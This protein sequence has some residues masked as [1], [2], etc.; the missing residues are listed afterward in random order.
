M[1]AVLG[2]WN[3]P[4]PE[5]LFSLKVLWTGGEL[6]HRHLI[7]VSM[8]GILFLTPILGL[9]NTILSFTQVQTQPYLKCYRV[10]KRKTNFIVPA[11]Q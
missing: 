6:E 10:I 8:D 1:R 7:R 3:L 11:A 9:F 5:Q 4:R 2:S